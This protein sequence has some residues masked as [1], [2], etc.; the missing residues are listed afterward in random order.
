M[1]QVCLFLQKAY[2]FTRVASGSSYVTLSFIPLIYDALSGQ[3][4][5][6]LENHAKK[7]P[8]KIAVR[9]AADSLLMKLDKYKESMLSELTRTAEL[10]DPR[11]SSSSSS[12]ATKESFRKLLRNQHE[13]VEV[14]DGPV[15]SNCID[16]D[17]SLL[18]QEARTARNE[19]S[20]VRDRDYRFFGAYKN[21][22]YYVSSGGRAAGKF[23]HVARC[24]RDVL[25]ITGASVAS[26]SAFSGSGDIVSPERSTN[27]DSNLHEA[28]GYV[29][30][31]ELH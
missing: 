2:R 20:V 25:M 16:S 7:T 9:R 31:N 13:Y 30:F 8:I 21:G 22:S 14:Q 15:V 11:I 19:Q 17:R 1:D 4:H 6:E 24:A 5:Q 12:Q 3:C 10:L 26:E 29:F 28:H 27:A 23:P 18:L